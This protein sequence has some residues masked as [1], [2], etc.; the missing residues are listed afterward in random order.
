MDETDVQAAGR[1][2][3]GQ[4]YDGGLANGVA[5]TGVEGLKTVV[6]I[7]GVSNWHE[8]RSPGGTPSAC[9]CSPTPTARSA[10]GSV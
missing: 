2:M 8:L 7:N 4:G 5:A 9:R 3:I 10:N 1:A 6:P